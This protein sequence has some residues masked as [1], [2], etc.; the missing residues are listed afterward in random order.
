MKTHKQKQV[1]S[2]LATGR[3]EDHE[4]QIYSVR[5]KRIL[6]PTILPSGYKQ[7][8]I[9]NGKRGKNGISAVVYVHVLV[10]MIN[11]GEYPDGYEIDHIDR[12]VNNNH[13]SNLRAVDT[14]TNNSNRSNPVRGS[15]QK[16]IRHEE[17]NLIRDLH[18]QGLNQSDIAKR[19]N[20]NRLSVRYIIKKIE[21]G[22]SLKYE[23]G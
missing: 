12:N 4:G 2:I 13:I 1:M 9:F 15:N 7:V 14:K 11:F 22:E 19:L 23:R 5:S 18:S 20:L 3:Y 16:N 17:I 10:Y 8:K 6:S 21:S